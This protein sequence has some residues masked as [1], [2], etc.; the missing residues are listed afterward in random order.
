MVVGRTKK[1]HLRGTVE[2]VHMGRGSGQVRE[3]A[4]MRSCAPE[5]GEP[6]AKFGQQR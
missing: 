1:G 2:E 4:G 6:C 3:E 5:H